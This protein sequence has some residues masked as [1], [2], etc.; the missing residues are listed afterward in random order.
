MHRQSI[1]FLLVLAP[2]LAFSQEEASEPAVTPPDE[3]APLRDLLDNEPLVVDALREYDVAQQALFEW[4]IALARKYSET[5]QQELAEQKAEQANR[6]LELV[7]Q[8]YEIVLRNY[9]KNPRALNYYGELMY[10][11]YGDHAVGLQNWKMSAQLDED[12]APPRNNLAVYYSHTGNYDLMMKYL[13]EALELDPDNPDFLFNAAQMYLIHFPQI[14]RIKGWNKEKI[15]KKAMAMS[16]KASELLPNDFELAE[17]Y[18]VNF[19]ASENFGVEVDWREAA[20]AWEHAR[21]VAHNT[22]EVF[23]TWINEARAWLQ[24]PNWK[25][26]RV[27]VEKALEIRPESA[28]AQTLM[29]R[30]KEQDPA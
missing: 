19:W 27:C 20:A 28:A 10:D 22:D 12:F 11:R 13:D 5:G 26:A 16:R 18:A 30:I 21:S 15:F 9:P 25:R 24:V 8:A 2:L 6:R 17:D 7:K 23:N 4:D 29:R 1:I 3:L 14:Q